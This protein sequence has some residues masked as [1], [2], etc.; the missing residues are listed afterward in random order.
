MSEIVDQKSLASLLSLH[1]QAIVNL[2]QDD[3]F[4]IYFEQEWMIAEFLSLQNET[5]TFWISDIDHE[6]TE[7][8]NKWEHFAPYGTHTMKKDP[9]K[10]YKSLKYMIKKI[11]KRK[12]NKNFNVITKKWHDRQKKI[13][14]ISRTNFEKNKLI[15]SKITGKKGQ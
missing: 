7:N 9:T 11:K 5:I 6:G 3:K 2:E 1:K 13:Y 4:D 12:R 14:K 8:I 10:Q 15:I